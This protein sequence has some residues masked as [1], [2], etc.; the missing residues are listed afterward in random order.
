MYFVSVSSQT[1]RK[2]LC[3]RV[4]AVW[5]APTGVLGWKEL[6]AHGRELGTMEINFYFVTDTP[7]VPSHLSW[8]SAF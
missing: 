6:P 5:C 8:G 7:N 4:T 1:E 3:G 2:K